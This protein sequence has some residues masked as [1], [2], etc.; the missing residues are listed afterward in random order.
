MMKKLWAE[1]F[2]LCL[3]MAQLTFGQI[4]KPQLPQFETFQPTRLGSQNHAP[5]FSN[6]YDLNRQNQR[7][8]EAYQKRLERQRQID[9]LTKE[10]IT[11]QKSQQRNKAYAQSRDKA[12]FAMAEE[13][14]KATKEETWSLKKLVF[15][16]ENT[17]L[18][19][20][21]KYQDFEKSIDDILLLL[22]RYAK[23]QK[24]NWAD[25]DVR[26]K[27]LLN[28]FVQPFVFL[29]GEVHTPPSYDHDNPL[30]EGDQAKFF[31]SKLLQENTGQCFSIPLLYK[32]LAE[33]INV[34]AQIATA[35]NHSYIKFRDGKGNWYNYE[36]THKGFP[37]DKWIMSAMD[38][39]EQAIKN[40][41]YMKGI[42]REGM[43]VYLLEY[44]IE[45]YVSELGQR[46][47][48]KQ[49]TSY[50]IQENPK[51]IKAWAIKANYET[52]TLRQDIYEAGVKSPNDLKNY[53]ELYKRHLALMKLYDT[54]DAL[55]FKDM[56]EEEYQET[57]NAHN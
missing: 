56:S 23:E 27:T 2:V 21:L 15:E 53:P 33:E 30:G 25:Y 11:K 50:C 6:Q 1:V 48:V 57:V 3:L 49:Y 20:Q 40:E 41:I 7:N 54:I 14:I 32:I 34:D 17:Y 8:E 52:I 26:Q 36:T 37:P 16:I 12:Y 29:N 31:V 47:F 39:S 24:L 13:I 38:V 4:Q 42:S 28:Y 55:G 43:K 19:G 45:N 46:D 44:L 18:Q 51:S 35:P 9:E 10:L 5:S 22:K